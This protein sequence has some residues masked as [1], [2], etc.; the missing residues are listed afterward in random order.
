[1]FEVLALE[2]IEQGTHVHLHH[3]VAT[4]HLINLRNLFSDL[5][6]TMG[7]KPLKGNESA[8][9]NFQADM[10]G[11]SVAKCNEKTATMK[12]SKTHASIATSF[13]VLCT[14][15]PFCCSRMRCKQR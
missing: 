13:K 7:H 2:G 1:M 3:L 10:D 12:I 8:M 15:I 6:K 9:K 5:T 4:W 14:Y 11:Q